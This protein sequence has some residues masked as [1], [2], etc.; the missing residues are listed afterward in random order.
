[1]ARKVNYTWKN[2]LNKTGNSS[3]NQSIEPNDRQ[4]L[5]IAIIDTETSEG[6]G[7]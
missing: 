7:I 6:I 2:N 3:S 4:K 1:M 5:I